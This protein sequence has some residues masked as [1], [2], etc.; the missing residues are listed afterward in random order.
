MEILSLNL[1]HC[2]ITTGY[3]ISQ[4]FLPPGE[5]DSRKWIHPKVDYRK[6]PYFS[7]RPYPQ[8]FT[9]RFQFKANLSI[10]D[11]IFNLGPESR[12]NLQHSFIS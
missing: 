4:A 9:E 6:D 10:L 1:E 7:P 2:G 12:E 5:I 3:E 11:M 8:V